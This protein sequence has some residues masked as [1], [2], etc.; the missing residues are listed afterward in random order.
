MTRAIFD[1]PPTGLKAVVPMAKTVPVSGHTPGKASRARMEQRAA[2]DRAVKEKIDEKERVRAEEE[3][4]KADEEERRYRESRKETVVW[5][6]PVPEA[7]YGKKKG[8]GVVG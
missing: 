6:K 1:P 3:R 7:L 5:A 4:K 8:Q 2:F